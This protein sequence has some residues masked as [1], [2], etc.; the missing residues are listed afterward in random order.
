[1]YGEVPEETVSVPTRCRGRFP[2]QP[3]GRFLCTAGFFERITSLV[4]ISAPPVRPIEKSW[5]QVDAEP[6]IIEGE[7]HEIRLFRVL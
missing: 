1:L 5:A 7:R 6:V 3:N 2:I 4:S